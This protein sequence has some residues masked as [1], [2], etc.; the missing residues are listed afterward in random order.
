MTTNLAERQVVPQVD[1]VL[2]TKSTRQIILMQVE[3]NKLP[4]FDFKA[5]RWLVFLP[6]VMTTVGCSRHSFAVRHKVSRLYISRMVWPGITK[7][8]LAYRVQCKRALKNRQYHIRH[9]CT[10]T[11]ACLSNHGHSCSCRSRLQLARRSLCSFFDAPCTQSHLTT[12]SPVMAARSL[13]SSILCLISPRFSTM[14]QQQSSSHAHLFVQKL[15]LTW[16]TY[17]FLRVFFSGPF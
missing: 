11:D 2:K 17:Y 3:I 1:E 9:L 10:Q 7:F 4:Q 6:Y 12:A 5:K 8:L 15:L 13:N 14:Y 16:L